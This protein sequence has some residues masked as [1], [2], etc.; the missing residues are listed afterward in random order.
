MGILKKLLNNRSRKRYRK[1]MTKF[2]SKE[3]SIDF[4]FGTY[5]GEEIVKQ[6]PNLSC[7]YL[8]GSNVV[9]VSDEDEIKFYELD[10]ARMKA[11]E[12]SVNNGENDKFIQFSHEL[13]KKYL[14]NPLVLRLPFF[15]YNNEE[16]FK[17]G[18][19][20]ALWDCDRC[21]YSVKPEDIDILPPRGYDR[22]VK[23]KFDY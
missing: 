9:Q 13:H 12:E 2:V 18:I 1:R 3:H 6:L 21:A 23:L 4:Y 11:Y 5:V 20:R 10:D 19:S 15:I 16:D 22:I 8:K 7:D 17:E 14:P